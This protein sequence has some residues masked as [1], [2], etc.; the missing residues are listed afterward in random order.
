DYGIAANIL[1]NLKVKS[2]KLLTN[3]P[4]KIR[5]LIATGIKIDERLPLITEPTE[6]SKA[7][8]D[9]KAKRSGHLFGDLAKTHDIDKIQS[10]SDSD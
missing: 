8:I 4:E 9:T 10:L 6:F 1:N 5:Q 7:Y 3:N 2:I